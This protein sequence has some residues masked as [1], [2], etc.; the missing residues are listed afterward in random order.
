MCRQYSSGTALFTLQR[1]RPMTYGGT[2][3][4]VER[5]RRVVRTGPATGPARTTGPQ[6]PATRPT[7][8]L[9]RTRPAEMLDAV[10]RLD[11]SLGEKALR[12]TV[13]WL[14]EQYSTESGTVLLG[15]VAKCHLGRPYVD[16]Q[17]GLDGA[18]LR[19]FA[20]GEAMPEPFN[21]ARMLARSGAYAYIE[22]YDKGL[23]LPIMGD[24]TVVYGT[25]G[26]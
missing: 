5:P 6:T 8:D 14:R 12:Q 21:G 9:Y 15:F 2:M 16:H 24:G 23:V 26:L 18:I 11:A 20:P 1:I 10:R 4:F 17:V 22:V 19:H 3:G 7:K 25:V 13:E